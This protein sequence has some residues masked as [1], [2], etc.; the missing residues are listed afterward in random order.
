MLAGPLGP[1]AFHLITF[2]RFISSTPLASFFVPVSMWNVTSTM[3]MD[4]S[5]PLLGAM[6]ISTAYSPYL[7]LVDMYMIVVIFPT[8]LIG[9]IWCVVCRSLSI[10]LRFEI[11]HNEGNPLYHLRCLCN[12]YVME[13]VYIVFWASICSHLVQDLHSPR[14]FNSVLQQFDDLLS[15]FQA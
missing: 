10:T 2:A 6:S 7:A 4:R 8:A 11:V 15:A 3:V 1:V 12:W 13:F 5:R 9:M 14:N